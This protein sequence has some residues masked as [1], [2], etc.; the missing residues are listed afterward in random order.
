[1]KNSLI[2]ITVL[3]FVFVSCTNNSEKATQHFKH[4]YKTLSYTLKLTDTLAILLDSKTRYNGIF[5]LETIDNV[6]YLGILNRNENAY[7]L[8][9]LKTFN[10]GKRIKFN[11]VGPNG[12]GQAR[13]VRVHNWD[14]I[15]ITRYHTNQLYLLDSS[16]RVKQKWTLN[17]TVSGD[18]IFNINANFYFKLVFCNKQLYLMNISPAKVFTKEY[19]TTVLGLRFNP[20]GNKLYNNTGYFPK[21]YKNGICFG[22]WNNDGYRIITKRGNQVYSF[23]LDNHLYVYN[24]T[25]LI[26]KVGLRSPHVPVDAPKPSKTLTGYNSQDDWMYEIQRG[27]YRWL[28]Y[29]GYRDIIYRLVV[30][31]MEPYD[32]EGNKNRFW[33]K[34]FSIQ[35]I[36]STFS[37]IGEVDFPGKQ[38]DFRNIIPTK[39]GLL[40][41][42]CHDDNPILEEDKLKLA[43]FKLIKTDGKNN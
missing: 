2:I 38:Y 14:S 32:A 37:L 28:A 9:N 11:R 33:D 29:D 15:F 18:L 13:F 3:L 27:S 17:K 8:Y 31:A 5:K 41:S 35:I 25:A 40:I 19:W 22:G 43:L 24:D 34:P 10:F 4:Q 20:F 36:D 42:L 16:A 7:T 21:I 39:E 30:H 1:M 23:S 6:E 12:I 26:K